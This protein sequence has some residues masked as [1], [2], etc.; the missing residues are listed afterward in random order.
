MAKYTTQ[1]RHVV[2]SGVNLFDFDYPIFDQAYKPVLEQKIIDHYYFREIGLETVAQF[3]HF[4]K[5]KMRIIMPYYNEQYERLNEFKSFDAYINKDLTTTEKRTV[6]QDRDNESN[7]ENESTANGKGVFHDTP[8]GE[9]LNENYA[10]EITTNE[11]NDISTGTSRGNE[12]VTGTDDYLQT[13]KGFDGMKY[14]SD[15]YKDIRETLINID[16]MVISELQVL[17]MNIY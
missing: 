17:F 12:H 4:L 6:T 9:I 5:S 1:L 10:T 13:V 14:A 8:Q 2:D 3:K 11:G 15:V 16:E 7:I